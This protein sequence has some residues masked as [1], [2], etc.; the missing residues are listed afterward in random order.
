MI[1]RL[2]KKSLV[3]NRFEIER[4]A[5]TGGMGSVYQARDRYSGEFVALKLLHPAG[6]SASEVDRFARE[7]LV[8]EQLHHPGIVAHVAHGQTPDGQLFL[9]MQWLEG[10]DLAE[11]LRRGP[12]AIC[13]SLLLVRH[14]AEALAVAHKHGVIHRD[15]KPAN[16]F[17]P[18]S[19]TERVTVLDFG[20]AQQVT[21]SHAVTRTGM[22]VGTPQYMAP[23]QARGERDLSPAADLF[24]LGCV[25]YECLCGAP[26]FVGEHVAAVLMRILHEEPPWLSDSGSTAPPPLLA[27]LGKLLAK[28]PARRPESADKLIE[29]IDALGLLGEDLRHTLA[30]TAVGG[31]QPAFSD[32]EQALFCVILASAPSSTAPPTLAADGLG[33]A[34]KER[35]EE[36]SR[37]LRGLGAS[38]EWLFDGSLL[39]MLSGAGSATDQAIQAARAALILKEAWSDAEV[40]LATGRA[41]VHAALPVGEAADRAARLLRGHTDTSAAAPATP[42]P[43]AGVWLDELSAGLLQRRFA[44]VTI[45]GTVLLSGEELSEDESRPLLG[46]PTP[47]VGREQELGVLDA[48]LTGCIEES[49][50]QA[51]L[52]TAP[53]G[54]G[55]SRLRH[56]LMRRLAGRAEAVSVLIGWGEQMTAGSPYAMLSRALKKLCAIQGGEPLAVQRERLAQRLGLHLPAELQRHTIDFLGE[57]CG[58]PCAA[59]ESALLRAARSD[60]KIMSDQFAEAFIALLRAECAVAPVLLVF[61]DLHWGDAMTVKLLTTALRDLDDQPLMIAALARPEVHELFPKLWAGCR[62][63][64]LTLRGLSRKASERLVQQVLG[65]QVSKEELARIVELA[66]GNALFLEELIRAQA[67]GKGAALP[68]TVLAI[69]QARIGRLDSPARRVLR[70]ASIFGLTFWRGGIARLMQSERSKYPIDA[71]LSQLVESELI[72]VHGGSR[73][74]GEPEYGFRHALIREAA[75]GLLTQDDRA[76]GHRLA[77]DYLDDAGEPDALILAEHF[78][79]GQLPERAAGY[80]LR[81]GSQ[82]FEHDDLAGALLRAERG[83]NCEAQGETLGNLQ[84]LAA[85]AHCWRSDIASGYRMSVAAL[86]LIR[87]TSRW[88]CIVLFHGT[89]SSLVLGREDDFVAMATQLVAA[90]PDAGARRDYLLWCPLAA[91]L[92]TSYGRRELARD[93]LARVSD[94]LADEVEVDPNLLGA[95]AVGRSDYVRA[96]ERRPFEP[97]LLTRDAVKAFEQI[98]DRRNLVTAQ[99]RLG[100]AQSEL[101]DPD[102]AEQTL[103][104]AVALAERIRVPFA[105][106]QAELHLAALF[107]KS[108]AADQRAEAVAIATKVLGTQGV[109]LGYCGWARGILAQVLLHDGDCLSAE[110]ES[111]AALELCR[112]VPLRRLWVLTL[113][114][115]SL[116]FRSQP[117]EARALAAEIPAAIARLGGGG[118]VEIDAYLT[119]AQAA[120]AAGA[121]DEAHSV[122][123]QT[124]SQLKLRADSIPDP[125]WRTRYLTRVSENERA[126]CLAREW[127]GEAI[128]I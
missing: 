63:R 78:E 89:W 74:A 116:L 37:T 25:L 118:Y 64:E 83:I 94:L 99:S 13:D 8:L 92:L 80:Y 121:A 126:A 33:L 1:A 34:E 128:V 96:F 103:R 41:A 45:S 100:Q 10:E 88:E 102:A 28:D 23:E 68:E 50:A 122:L 108:P 9:A 39:A 90:Q 54:V 47:C 85:M 6:V 101:G 55:K 97:L 7:A 43:A 49:E 73:F 112:H 69:L 58:I 81:A 93:L 53:P 87:R 77:G 27:L 70:A 17:L 56:E 123:R 26:P 21:R 113:L 48:L 65:K 46:R 114:I 104:G 38:V 16:L 109:G 2:L 3:A 36:L 29:E 52:I 91:S 60:P 61:E 18:D 19:R 84:A 75:Y 124:L 30:Q 35:R 106:L 127:L 40:A 59:A 5:G 119:S 125:D 67:E 12:M 105:L 57:L 4:L 110:R 72:E 62:L 11:R 111:R 95:Q 71:A 24:S 14:V 42:Q 20:I 22:V 44:L 32:D 86:P 115:R 107:C 82:S 117:E 98:G 66:A 51:V 120:Q 31:G 79:R 15:L 76:L